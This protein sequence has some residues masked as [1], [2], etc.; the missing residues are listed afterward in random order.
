[1]WVLVSED[2][3]AGDLW[4]AN[5]GWAMRSMRRSGGVIEVI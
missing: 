4:N 3:V 5:C 1:M 2:V